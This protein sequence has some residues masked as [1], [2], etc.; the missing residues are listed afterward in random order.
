MFN[1][2][3]SLAKDRRWQMLPKIWRFLLITVLIIGIVF[4]FAN[5]TQKVY[6]YDEV[7]TSLTIVGYAEAEI[8]QSLNETD[9]IEPK[10]LQKYQNF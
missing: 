7:S 4:R 1:L 6:W 8:V 3:R 2:Q 5:L 9:P 10:T